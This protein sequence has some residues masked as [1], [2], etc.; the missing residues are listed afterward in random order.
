MP[1]SAY[2]KICLYAIKNHK[3]SEFFNLKLQNDAFLEFSDNVGKQPII[4][5]K[6]V[7]GHFGILKK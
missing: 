5:R 7:E 4:V 1:L 2:A 6:D 3:L